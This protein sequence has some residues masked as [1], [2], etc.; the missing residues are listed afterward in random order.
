MSYLLE[1]MQECKEGRLVERYGSK[2]LFS[3]WVLCER[4]W[5]NKGETHGCVASCEYLDEDFDRRQIPIT[6][7]DT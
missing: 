4:Y 5:T 3:N 6:R 7:I 1:G 2:A